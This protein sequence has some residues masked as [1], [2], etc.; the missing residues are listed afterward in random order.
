MK[1]NNQ[2]NIGFICTSF[3]NVAGGLERQI[4]RTSISLYSKGF[5]VYLFSFDNNKAESFYEIPN[6]II[7][8]KC[9]NGLKP[10][11]PANKID[12]LKQILNL[13]KKLKKYNINT[14]ISF[15]HGIFPR[16]YLASF[17]LKIRHIVSER[18]SLSNYKYIKLR[19]YNLGFLSLYLA[20]KITI[21]LDSYRND[22]PFLLRQKIFVINNIIKKPLRKYKMPNLE[23]NIVSMA[24]RLCEQKNFIPLIN[25]LNVEQNKDF[26]IIIAGEG[27]LRKKFEKDYA[28]LIKKSSLILKGNVKNIDDFFSS[29]SIF[30]FPSLWEGYPNSLAEALRM[31]MPIVT[32]NRMKYLHEFVEHN[33]NG[34]IVEDDKLLISIKK[35]IKNK[36]KLLKMSR[37]S[38]RKYYELSKSNPVDKWVKL[39]ELVNL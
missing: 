35:L 13:R 32:S 8:I 5:K 9:G 11:A 39:V 20:H 2:K 29:S 38:Y 24:G 3:D 4:I 6:E 12:R 21:Q 7:W 34:L 28:D 31:G 25:Q 33:V 22:Y 17:F 30:C 10:H 37:Q 16:V 14:L 1:K 36:S 26:K 18:N 27:H 15:H 23:Q 19:K